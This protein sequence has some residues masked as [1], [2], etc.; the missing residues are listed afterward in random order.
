MIYFDPMYFLFL[1]PAI[2]LGLWAQFRVKA[3]FAEAERVGA[4]ISGAEAARKVLDAAGL[5]D[6]GIEPVNGFL[7]DHNWPRWVS[8]N[9][10]NSIMSARF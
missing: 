8:F 9:G 10:R 7:S 5:Y 4:E 3:T 1:A 2:L 6:V